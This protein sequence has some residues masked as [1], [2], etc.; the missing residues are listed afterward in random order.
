MKRCPG[1]ITAALFLVALPAAIA[2]NQDYGHAE[3]G[4]FADYFGFQ[5][6]SPVSV[7]CIRVE[8]SRLLPD[9]SDFG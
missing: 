8:A 9:Q 6:T 3:I 1:L 7:P 4:V 5:Q 2:Q